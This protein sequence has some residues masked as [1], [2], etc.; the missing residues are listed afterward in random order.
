[1]E[2]HGLVQ[3]EIRLGG[4]GVGLVVL[5]RLLLQLQDDRVGPRAEHLLEHRKKPFWEKSNTKIY[6]N[7]RGNKIIFRNLNEQLSKILK[8]PK[9]DF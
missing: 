9:R 3:R 5:L 7:F 8:E 1:M 6:E 2:P 4:H